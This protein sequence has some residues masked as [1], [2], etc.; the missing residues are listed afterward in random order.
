MSG[1]SNIFID[2]FLIKYCNTYYGIYASDNIPIWLLKKKRFSIIVNLSKKGEKGTHY[3]AI[4]CF[5][6]YVLYIDSFGIPCYVNDI[7]KFLK[8]IE[9]PIKFNLKHQLCINYIK[10]IKQKFIPK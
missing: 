1:L 3:I 9:R 5:P 4:I 8:S 7:C 10:L 6:S 2:E